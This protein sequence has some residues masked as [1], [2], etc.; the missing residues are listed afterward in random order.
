M[1]NSASQAAAFYR[2]VARHQ[3]VWTVRDALGFPAPMTD[4]GRRSAPFWSSLSRVNKI[5]QTVP[6]YSGFEPHEVPWAV[7]CERWI[8]GLA[9]DATLVGVNWSGPHA[10]GYDLEPHEVRANVEYAMRSRID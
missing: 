4:S 6:A 7:F 10:T 3:M 5:I 2:E 8:P 9:K 1:S